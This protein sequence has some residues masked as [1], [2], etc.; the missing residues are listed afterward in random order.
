MTA[1]TATMMAVRIALKAV[2]AAPRRVFQIPTMKAI[3]LFQAPPI[4]AMVELKAE[5]M[6][7]FTALKAVTAAATRVC[8]S[9]TRKAIALFQAPATQLAAATSIFQAAI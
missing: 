7:F 2:V 6:A 8:H 3:A 4:Q 5:T 9:P 1:L